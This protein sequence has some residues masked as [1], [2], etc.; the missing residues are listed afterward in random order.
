MGA[1]A[2]R[3]CWPRKLGGVNI[4]NGPQDLKNIGGGPQDRTKAHEKRWN[5][6]ENLTMGRRTT[7][8]SQKGAGFTPK[9]K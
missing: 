9:Q 1:K 5:I 3:V 8:I 4:G 7:A 6:R 2:H